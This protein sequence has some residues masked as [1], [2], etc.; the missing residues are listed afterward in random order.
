MN[1]WELH[2]Q[3]LT[4]ALHDLQDKYAKFENQSAGLA[5]DTVDSKNQKVP[6]GHLKAAND[7]K[8]DRDNATQ[9]IVD[10][11]LHDWQFAQKRVQHKVDLDHICKVLIDSHVVDHAQVE[12][13]IDAL[14]VS[15]L[16][17]REG[18]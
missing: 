8:A 18:E 13:I 10:L 9:V 3:T 2:H 6:L 12:L 15:T 4:Q 16:I 14:T 5:R 7:A 11:K 17:M 1:K